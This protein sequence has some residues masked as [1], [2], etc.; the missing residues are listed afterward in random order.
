MK[1][2]TIERIGLLSNIVRIRAREHFEFISNVSSLM[3]SDDESAEY[4]EGLVKRAFADDLELQAEILMKMSH[5][6][7]GT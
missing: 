5:K 1:L 2:T 7:M 4:R 3:G 6:R